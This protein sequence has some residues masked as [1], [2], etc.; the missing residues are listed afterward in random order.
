M[1]TYSADIGFRCYRGK[2]PP[3][4]FKNCRERGK[5][6]NTVAEMLAFAELTRR[7][8]LASAIDEFDAVVAAPRRFHRRRER[9][10]QS[11]RRARAM[12]RRFTT[13]QRDVQ[14]SVSMPTR[15]IS[16]YAGIFAHW[17]PVTGYRRR[18]A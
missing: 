9:I 7:P 14:R 2:R 17:R 3:R 6:F 16:I 18:G 5:N 11:L 15:P 8:A 12:R 4:N 13:A 1:F 10:S